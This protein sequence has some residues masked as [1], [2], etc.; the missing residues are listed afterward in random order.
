MTVNFDLGN[1]F[2]YF[3]NSLFFT[4]NPYLIIIGSAV[5]I[6]STLLIAII[7]DDLLASKRPY[8]D[9]LY[10]IFAG[11]ISISFLLMF[12]WWIFAFGFK[13]PVSKAYQKAPYL[14]FAN[15][16]MVKKHDSTEE[17]SF[18]HQL[19]AIRVKGTSLDI[20]KIE[21]TKPDQVEFK[22]INKVGQ[23][24]LT[25]AKFLT[26]R[27]VQQKGLTFVIKANETV[28]EYKDDRGWAKVKAT[29][30][31]PKKLIFEQNE[32]QPDD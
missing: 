11:I 29:S 12:I 25:V 3:V 22:P 17:L 18:N 2:S 24:C 10:F 16:Q 9:K 21:W 14:D 13:N 20:A 19:N 23:S 31:N 4:V 1:G 5:V 7:Y 15:V 28:A 27:H 30:I 8:R 26:D 6:L 32:N